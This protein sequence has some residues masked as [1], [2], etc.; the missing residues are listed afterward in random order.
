VS[1]VPPGGIFDGPTD[2]G[3]SLQRL[4][5]SRSS[6]IPALIVTGAESIRKWTGEMN[7]NRRNVQRE[8][9]FVKRTVD[10]RLDRNTYR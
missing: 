10:L 2:A 1:K 5:R 8:K 9:E 6:S 4:D 3:I 7:V